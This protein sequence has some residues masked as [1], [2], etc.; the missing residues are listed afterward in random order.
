MVRSLH[1]LSGVWGMHLGCTCRHIRSDTCVAPGASWLTPMLVNQ[2][3][4][5]HAGLYSALLDVTSSGLQCH[6]VPHY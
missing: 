3:A 6:L 1:T 2:H 4:M 5:A